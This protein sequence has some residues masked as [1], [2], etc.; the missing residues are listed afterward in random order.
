MKLFGEIVLG[1]FVYA[2]AGLGSAQ[3]AYMLGGEFYLSAAFFVAFIIAITWD[4]S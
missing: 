2:I 4:K 3:L 1:A